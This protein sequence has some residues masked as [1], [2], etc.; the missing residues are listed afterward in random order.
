MKN[1]IINLDEITTLDEA[2]K[3]ISLLLES[4][5]ASYYFLYILCNYDI[6]QFL[7]TINGYTELMKKE[8][9]TDEHSSFLETISSVEQNLLEFINV[10]ARVAIHERNKSDNLQEEHKS[11]Q[12]QVIDLQPFLVEGKSKIQKIADDENKH[13]SRSLQFDKRKPEYSALRQLPRVETH[14]DITD[15]LPSVGFDPEVLKGIISNVV[16][17][18]TGYGIIVKLFIQTTFDEKKVKLIF[19]CLALEPRIHVLD[20]FQRFETATTIFEFSPQSLSFYQNWNLLKMYGG[21]LFLDV[22]DNSESQ[23]LS[24][25]HAT[26]VLKR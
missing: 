13:P 2:K 19:G 22:Q 17:L 21:E 3:Q 11:S 16:D 5:K 20:D 23:Q 10:V 26:I 24:T 6:K 25:A 7:L 9:F 14:F 4:Q 18:I 15:N 8:E 1:K 12:S